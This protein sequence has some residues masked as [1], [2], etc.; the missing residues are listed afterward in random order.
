MKKDGYFYYMYKLTQKFVLQNFD[1]KSKQ[2]TYY[3]PVGLRFSAFDCI[4]SNFSY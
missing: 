3:G 2:H 1:R 4:Y